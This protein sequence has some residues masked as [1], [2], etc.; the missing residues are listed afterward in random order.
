VSVIAETA[1][2]QYLPAR[3]Q[4][5]QQQQRCADCGRVRLPTPIRSLK[6]RPHT[7]HVYA[8]SFDEIVDW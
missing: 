7:T 6:I 5:Q 8:G 2:V 1:R 4:Q 3:Q